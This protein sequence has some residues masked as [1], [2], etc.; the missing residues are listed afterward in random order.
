MSLCFYSRL[1]VVSAVLLFGVLV[2]EEG[3]SRRLTTLRTSLLRLLTLRKTRH[4]LTLES[5]SFSIAFDQQTALIEIEVCCF[6]AVDL[7]SDRWS[8]LG[9]M[10]VIY[11]ILVLNRARIHATSGPEEK[12]CRHSGQILFLV[13]L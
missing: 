8:F 11:N 12:I 6:I 7:K 5:E 1:R 9:A 4:G 3:V 13:D 10:A 2:Q